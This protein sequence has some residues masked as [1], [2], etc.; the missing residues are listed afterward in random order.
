MEKREPLYIPGRIANWYKLSSSFLPYLSRFLLMFSF[1]CLKITHIQ[2]SPYS[3]LSQSLHPFSIGRIYA[4]IF[5]AAHSL[6]TAICT[7]IFAYSMVFFH[8]Y[9]IFF[10]SSFVLFCLHHISNLF[11]WFIIQESS[12]LLL[13]F[14]SLFLRL[15]GALLITLLMWNN[16]SLGPVTSPF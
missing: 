3:Y 10:F 9:L 5:F 14:W 13:K 2:Y 11:H 8:I 16:C 4:A 7:D 1:L 15:I 12:V 6:P